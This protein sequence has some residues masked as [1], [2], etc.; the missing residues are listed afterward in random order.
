MP[1][2][3]AISAIGR[4]E[5]T[6]QVDSVAFELGSELPSGASLLVGHLDILLSSEVSCLRGEIHCTE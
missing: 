6:H 4:P 1:S 3:R 2:S 5:S